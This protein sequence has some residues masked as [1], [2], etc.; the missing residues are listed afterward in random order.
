MLPMYVCVCGMYV[1]CT[2]RDRLP[3]AAEE[4]RG[5]LTSLRRRTDEED[6]STSPVPVAV[7]ANKIDAPG[8]MGEAEVLYG[9][10][11]YHMRNGGVTGQSSAQP[12]PPLEVFMCS[13]LKKQGYG[14]AFRWIATF[15]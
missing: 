15:L 12:Q 9:L 5:V 10:G 2:D 4:L 11:V 13:L 7:L 14:E 1:D 3:Q 6:A 8:A